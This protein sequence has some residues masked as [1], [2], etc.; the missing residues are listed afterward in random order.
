M[1]IKDEKRGKF[2][3]MRKGDKELKFIWYM[4]VAKRAIKIAV[5]Y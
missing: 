4:G 1:F 5:M 2:K 3:A